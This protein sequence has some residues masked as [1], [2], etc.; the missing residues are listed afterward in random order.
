[1]TVLLD[2]A[3]TDRQQWVLEH[4]SEQSPLTLSSATDEGEDFVCGYSQ[5][6]GI[7]EYKKAQSSLKR[8]LNQLKAAD[9][10]SVQKTWFP[11]TYFP[12]CGPTHCNEY[13]LE[14]RG[15]RAAIS[16]DTY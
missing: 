11:Q 15:R 16:H 13:H 4:M 9:L 8:V 2:K 6:F 10:V 14:N 1:M 5:E 3:L 12:D 7:P